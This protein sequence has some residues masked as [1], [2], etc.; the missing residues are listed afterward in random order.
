MQSA[1]VTLE[2]LFRDKQTNKYKYFGFSHIQSTDEELS[3]KK[4][5]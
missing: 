5:A 1:S 3:D 4:M 2:N